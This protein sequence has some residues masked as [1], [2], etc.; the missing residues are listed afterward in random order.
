MDPGMPLDSK[1][2]NLIL[3]CKKSLARREI[4]KHGAKFRYLLFEERP[5][6]HFLKSVPTFTTSRPYPN[7]SKAKA[8][9]FYGRGKALLHFGPVLV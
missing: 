9:A 7:S 5:H 3:S 8:L 2:L 1:I 4:K 6:L